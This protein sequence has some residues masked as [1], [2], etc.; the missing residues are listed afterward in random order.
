MSLKGFDKFREKTPILH[1]KRILILPVY[2]LILILFNFFILLQFYSF[3]DTFHSHMFSLTLLSLFPLLG[4]LIMEFLGFFLFSQIWVWRTKL[5]QKYGPTSYQHVFFIGFSGI[6]IIIALAFNLYIPFQHY[7]PVF[8]QIKGFSNVV[9][10]LETFLGN[11][12]EVFV[13]WT[14]I[15]LAFLFFLLGVLIMATA[16]TTFGIDYTTV[17]YLYFPEESILQNNQIYSVLRHPM[18]S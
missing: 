7:S 1:G 14:R 15:F 4:V 2:A 16:V 10:P 13:H 17:V 3:P 6:T 5:K 18:Y 11:Y 9:S 12:L 8:W